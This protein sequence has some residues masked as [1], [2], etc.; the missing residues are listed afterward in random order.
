MLLKKKV[1]FKDIPYSFVKTKTIF[2][3]IP[4]AAG[5]SITSAIYEH[6]VGHIPISIY[7]EI[8]GQDF[9]QYFKFT[10]VRNPIDRIISAF[11][12]LKQGGLNKL[13][14]FLGRRYVYKYNDINDFI[15]NFLNYE[16]IWSYIHFFPQY[17]FLL[18]EKGNI[19]VD[20]IGK[21]ETLEEDICFIEKILNKK[22]FIEKKN[23]TKNKEKVILD[24][25]SIDKIYDIYKK[26]FEIFNYKLEQT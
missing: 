24:S 5:I 3:H 19:L 14:Y 17:Y 4:K 12:F 26:D 6:E 20:F 9:N 22:L 1:F 18:D 15:R 16:S 13:D 23:T 2:T 10:F 8:L 21:V 11:Y 25:S 7:K